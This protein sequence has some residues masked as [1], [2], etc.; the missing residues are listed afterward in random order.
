MKWCTLVGKNELELSVEMLKASVVGD[1][2]PYAQSVRTA[3]L[4]YFTLSRLL[5]PLLLLSGMI[6]VSVTIALF[7][8]LC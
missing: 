2:R 1:C 8:P 7:D 6:E 3:D 5:S 4:G